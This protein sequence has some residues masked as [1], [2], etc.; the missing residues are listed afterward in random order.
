MIPKRFEIDDDAGRDSFNDCLLRMPPSRT[1][2]GWIA[3]SLEA[4]ARRR[5]GGTKSSAVSRRTRA[6]RYEELL[7]RE[8]ALPRLDLAQT[9]LRHTEPASELGLR[10]PACLA[11]LPRRLA[12]PGTKF[13]QGRRM[14]G[15][16]RI[17]T[18]MEISPWLWKEPV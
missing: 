12:D 18:A 3:G 15:G 2:E 11:Q 5:W 4:A 16:E 14:V 1:S 7:R 6:R 17:V 10:P 8:R 9:P 13:T